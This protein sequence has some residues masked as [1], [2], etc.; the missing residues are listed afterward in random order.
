MTFRLT[1]RP[2]EHEAPG[3]PFSV[4][5]QLAQH[6]NTNKVLLEP[7]HRIDLRQAIT[8]YPHLPEAPATELTVFALI[9]DSQLGAIDTP[10]GKVVFLQAVGVTAREK[11]A[12]VGSST[13]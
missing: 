3:W 8:G 2:D 1:K 7:G 10:N 11:A 4:L 6:V 13:S 5:N 12:M 9:V